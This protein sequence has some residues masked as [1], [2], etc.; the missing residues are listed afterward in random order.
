MKIDISK[1]PYGTDE[2]GIVLKTIT[3][4]Q[5][6]NNEISENLILNEKEAVL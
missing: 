3:K 2:K 6:L 4:E 5:V 1:K